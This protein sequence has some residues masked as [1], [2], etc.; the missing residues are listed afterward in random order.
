ML[1]PKIIRD[2]PDKIRKMLREY[3]VKHLVS[4]AGGCADSISQTITV[5]P[6]PVICFTDSASGCVP[7]TV[8]FTDCSLFAGTCSWNFGDGSPPETNCN[9]THIFSNPGCYDVTLTVTSPAGCQ[10]TLMQPCYVEGFPWPTADFEST[11]VEITIMNPLVN[12]ID[13]STG[14]TS[15]RWNFGDTTTTGDTSTVQ[16]PTYNY[17]DTGC[18]NVTLI[19]ENQ[20]GCTDTIV[21]PV[22]IIDISS[23]YVPNAFSPNADGTNDWFALKEHYFCEVEMYIFD[24]WGNLIYETTNL[25]GWDGTANGGVDVVQEDV[26]VWLVKA[27]DCEGRVWKRIGHVSVIR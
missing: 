10:V 7:L 17:P 3:V 21:K 26:Y 19:L 15:W 5:Y 11:P 23:I 13:K 6:T 27:K 9:P 8:D 2:E 16:N 22:C 1:D 14:A 25:K 4:D 18:Y 20:Y 24:R 12:F